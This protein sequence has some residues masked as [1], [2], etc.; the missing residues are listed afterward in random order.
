M[1]GMVS[2]PLVASFTLIAFIVMGYL[3]IPRL[4]EPLGA[5]GAVFVALPALIA[6]VGATD[7]FITTV[8][9]TDD[10]EETSR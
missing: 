1:G 2:V 5:L 4:L 3:G 10:T 8:L 6:G 9:M 7:F